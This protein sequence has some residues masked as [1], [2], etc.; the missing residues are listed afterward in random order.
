MRSSL[1]MGM[2]IG[3]REITKR[4]ELLGEL[5]RDAAAIATLRA[6]AAVKE[7]EV[8]VVEG[9]ADQATTALAAAKHRAETA[10]HD[11]EAL[12]RQI[13]QME[14]RM[15][16]I[17]RQRPLVIALSGRL[18]DYQRRLRALKEAIGPDPD[19][20]AI[21]R[22]QSRLRILQGVLFQRRQREL[23]GLRPPDPARLAHLEE[24]ERTAGAAP[25]RARWMVPVGIGAGVAVIVLVL[26][27]GGSLVAG[28]T[29]TIAVLIGS[30]MGAR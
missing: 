6:V 26:G 18:H 12:D 11:A 21:D 15:K 22:L 29:P 3:V 27:I 4:V 10:R 24:L 23:D 30:A 13:A 1:S 17:E 7:Q 5:R 14:P 28:V 25:G 20:E 19:R 2:S 9:Q 8:L 16:R